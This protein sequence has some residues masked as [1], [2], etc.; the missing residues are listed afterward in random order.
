M[1]IKNKYNQE[2]IW[3]ALIIIAFILFIC[4]LIAIPIGLP[5]AN[6]QI[7]LVKE[8]IVVQDNEKTLFKITTDTDNELIFENEDLLFIGKTN[9][10]K[11]T[12]ELKKHEGTCNLRITT[13]GYRIPFLSTYQNITKIEIIE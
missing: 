1:R 6:K 2:K 3:V 7:Y 13:R 4:S 11:F 12:F 10:S 5:Y 8:L 9:S